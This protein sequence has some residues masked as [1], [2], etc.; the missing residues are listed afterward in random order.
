M[1]RY[2]ALFCLALGMRV[3]VRR[4]EKEEVLV[5]A[6]RYPCTMMY[7]AWTSMLGREGDSRTLSG[8]MGGREGGVR[9]K[10]NQVSAC[11]LTT[12]R[13]NKHLA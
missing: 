6:P 1:Y 7:M 13:G 3:K 5:P 10:F 9:K 8:T 4:R 12:G 11:S 2:S